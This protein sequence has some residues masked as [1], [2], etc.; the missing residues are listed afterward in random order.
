MAAKI[1]LKTTY[2]EETG[3][4]AMRRL[5]KTGSIP[6]IVFGRSGE[7]TPVQFPVRDVEKILFSESGFNTIFK[8]SVD[9]AKKEEFPMVIVKE[10]QVDPVTHNFLHISFYRVHMDRVIEVNVPVHTIGVSPG[11]K[12]E[13]GNLDMVMREIHV[14]TLPANI[15]ES[16]EIDISELVINS[17]VRIKDITFPEGVEIDLDPEAV[18][19]QIT[20]PRVA[21]ETTEDEEGEEGIEAAEGEET[22]EEETE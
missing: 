4:N 11:V 2:R 20:P 19:L 10:Y 12:N 21:E 16:I 13:G 5:R 6:G 18:V 7:T 9:G 15:P 14:N 8:L 3:K 1:E 17:A 22:T